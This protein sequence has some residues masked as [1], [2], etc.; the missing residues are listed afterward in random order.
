MPSYSRQRDDPSAKG[1]FRR[2][3]LH[4]LKLIFLHK[5][6]FLFLTSCLISL[7]LPINI[8]GQNRNQ[9]EE[10]NHPV[11]VPGISVPSL[12]DKVGETWMAIGNARTLSVEQVSILPDG[13]V[14]AE[15]GLQGLTTRFYTNGKAKLAIEV[16]QTRF[17]SEA[18]GLFTFLRS[19]ASGK[20]QLFYVGRLSV[21]ISSESENLAMDQSF[22][23][24]LKK[25]IA[26]EEGELPSLPF[27]LPEEYKVSESE[28]YLTGPFAL[29]RIK[30]FAN[31]KDVISFAGGTQ[32]AIAN[33]QN[34]SRQ[35]SLVI[36]EYHTPQLATD[37]YAQIRNHFENLSPQEKNSRLLRRIGNYIVFA[38]NVQDRLVAENIFAKIKYAPQIS[39]EGRKIT[40]LPIQFRPTD[41]IV[42][43]E[44]S[45]TAQ[46][47]VRTFYWIGVMI[48]GAI[49]IGFIAGS[50]FFYWNRY[51]R[52]KLGIDDVFSDAGGTVRLNL[53][54]YLLEPK[55]YSSKSI[56][57]GKKADRE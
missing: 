9:N 37:G 31:L 49:L 40:D 5:P 35:M 28:K 14:Y 43:E 17:A 18:Y 51:R 23:N 57:E 46:M 34:G 8:F 39:W 6:G 1:V 16:F 27:N 24:L 32:A 44:A 50:S 25:G 3:A 13:D 42:F 54:D 56:T 12:P 38:T 29:A 48:F 45:Q 7:L 15:Y 52:R 55:D 22:V 33:Y 10:T 26:S 19:N 53:D 47:I 21:S 36:F 30:E 20:R 2:V 4:K 41:P 11:K